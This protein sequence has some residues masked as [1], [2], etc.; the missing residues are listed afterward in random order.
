MTATDK[1]IG[2]L[3]VGCVFACCL[4]QNTFAQLIPPGLTNGGGGGTNF[5]SYTNPPI[6]YVPGL[7]LSIPPLTGTNLFIHLLEADPAGKYD[8]FSA[9]N[10]VASSWSD[11]LQG[12]N[13]Q[14]NFTLPFPF[15]DTGFFR[16]A[17]T[18]TPVTNTA[19]MTISFPNPLINTNLAQ[20]IVTGGPAAA[21]AV[22]VNDTNLADAVWIPFSSVPLVLLG[23]N[24][25]VYQV[26]FGFIGGDGQTNWTSGSITIDTVPPLLVITSPTNNTVTQPMIQLQGYSIEALSRIKYNITNAVGMATNQEAFVTSQFTDTNTWMFTINYFQGFDI[27]LT[28][29]I[30][31]IVLYATDLAGNT[32][33]TNLNFTLDYSSKTNPPVVQISWPQNGARISGTNFTVDGQLDDPTAAIMVQIISTNAAT[34]TVMGLVGRDGKFW[35]ENLPLNAGT[36]ELT[37]TIEDAAGNTSVTNI[38]VV[39][40]D[41]TLTMNPVTPDSQLWQPTVSLSGTISDASYAVWVNGVKGTN[42]GDG[43]WSANN[44]PTT[45][46]GA[47]SFEIIAYAPDEQQPDGSFGN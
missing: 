10:L 12:T 20:A 24:D 22:L 9:S 8:I 16:A 5:I 43:T 1:L 15:T 36:N 35:A 25:G 47:A 45:S 41:L 17:R 38:S 14:T 29:G 26:T 34:N 23:T 32:T 11:M 28:N 19:T 42:N 3:I 39:Q 44:V 40:S 30:N 21:M 33:T 6:P 27:P 46:G 37:F 18:D 4:L 13:G 7:K 2:R 31:K